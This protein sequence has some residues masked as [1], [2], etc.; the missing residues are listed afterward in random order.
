MTPT[1]DMCFKEAEIY[2]KSGRKFESVNRARRPTLPPD[3]DVCVAL[4]KKKITDVVLRVVPNLSCS[5][6]EANA[7]L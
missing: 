7:Q 1:R 2:E 4:E 5:K 3:S 6:S